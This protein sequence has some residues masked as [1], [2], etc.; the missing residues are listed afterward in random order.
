MFS[1]Q[2]LEIRNAFESTPRR[3]VGMLSSQL[4]ERRER[5]DF[6]LPVSASLAGGRYVPSGVGVCTCLCEGSRSDGVPRAWTAACRHGSEHASHACAEM[7]PVCQFAYY[8]IKSGENKKVLYNRKEN[9]L[10]KIISK[11]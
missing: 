2:L 10:Q 5:N 4:L 9:I 8:F 11:E 6:S 7:L 3:L 1:S